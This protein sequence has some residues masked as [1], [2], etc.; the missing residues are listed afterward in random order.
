MLIGREVSGP[1][2]PPL[3]QNLHILYYISSGPTQ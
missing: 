2:P 1:S 3:D